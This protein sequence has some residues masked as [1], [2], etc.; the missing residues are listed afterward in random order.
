VDGAGGTISRVD[1]GT[2]LV[3]QPKKVA[4]VLSFAGFA[5]VGP[6][7]VWAAYSSGEVARV[8]P[9]LEN[10]PVTGFAGFH[11]LAIAV[12]AGSVWVANAGDD[13]VSQILPATASTI[14]QWQVGR[15]PSGVAVGAG[16]VWVTDEVDDTVFRIDPV[17]GSLTQIPVGHG[18]TG[19]AYGNG[20]VWVAD[21]GDG[22]VSEIDP[23]D[24]QHVVNVR[25]GNR[26]TGVAV[27]YGRVW[28]SVQAPT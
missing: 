11:P 13:T 25:V 24:L 12:G 21:S 1:P 20:H 28:V 9:S 8:D 17:S 10:A 18:P 4:Q 16:F 2:D 5:A 22:T 6:G 15:R 23:A 14:K 7:A 3:A 19:I 27:A 26:P